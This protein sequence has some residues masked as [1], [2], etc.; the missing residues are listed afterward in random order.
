MG[1]AVHHSKPT[2]SNRRAKVQPMPKGTPDQSW[3]YEAPL[4]LEPFKEPADPGSGDLQY[5]TPGDE[6]T[7]AEYDKFKGRAI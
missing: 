3:Q 7:P 6:Y 4:K 1:R 2:V 5:H